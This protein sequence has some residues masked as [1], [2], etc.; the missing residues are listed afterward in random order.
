MTASLKNRTRTKS[1]TASP[2]VSLL[3]PVHMNSRSFS[4]LTW[5]RAALDSVFDQVLDGILEIV[6]IEDSPALRA[7]PIIESWFGDRPKHP[8][9]FLKMPVNHGITRSLNLGL[10]AARG[11]YITRL[12]RDDEW[13]PGKLQRQLDMFDEDPDLALSFGGMELIDANGQFI[14]R[15]P[16]AFS[17]E[18][19]IYFSQHVGCP[20]PHGSIMAPR[21]VYLALGGYPY[22]P[23]AFSTEDFSLW[24]HL[25]RFFK[26]QG[27]QELFLKYRVHDNSISAVARG[28]QQANTATIMQNLKL[29]GDPGMLTSAIGRIAGDWGL[30][31]Y[32]TGLEL[33]RLWRFGGEAS[34]SVERLDD[35]RLVLFDRCIE[36]VESGTKLVVAVLTL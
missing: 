30:S 18:E 9:R 13:L 31:L 33:Q 32:E 5:L 20:I 28:P 10:E 7:Q 24:A 23:S 17:W 4:N 8:I 35:L 26:V 19:T 22:E 29:L 16:R 1:N 21:E 14:E 11:K 15:H 36:P 6:L 3:M 25:I 27:D 2:T 12:D 34:V